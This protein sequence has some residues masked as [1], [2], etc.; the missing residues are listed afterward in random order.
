MS[1]AAYL[2]H[3]ANYSVVVE[4]GSMSGAAERLVASA[5]AMSES[6]KILENYYGEPLLERHRSGVTPTTAGLSVYEHARDMAQAADRALTVKRRPQPRPK[7]RVSLPIELACGWFHDAIER[8]LASEAAPQLTLLAED[9]LLDHDRFSRDLYIRVSSSSLPKTLT[10]L[11]RH[12]TRS[13]LAA[14]RSL[15]GHRNPNRLS[16]IRTLPFLCKPHIGS[17][18]T[19]SMPKRVGGE[20]VGAHEVAF[21]RTVHVNDTQARIALARRGLG[22][23]G[24]IWDTLQAD[25]DSGD[26]VPLAPR[27]LSVPL[28]LH[29]VSPHRA[30]SA[31]V[32]DLA[33]AF[34]ASL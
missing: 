20:V 6:V 14:H 32:R 13:V 30:P 8:V 29:I 34:A 5:S 12:R 22:V 27:K 23:V 4:A 7:L 21:D 15:L 2:R 18:V 11:H 10:V 31:P 33:A 16:D 9:E 26:M 17:K 3:L 24:C 19:L 28:E 25:F 1:N